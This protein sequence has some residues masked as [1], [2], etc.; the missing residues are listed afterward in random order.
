MIKVFICIATYCEI[1]LALDI[2]L[3]D[4]I[5]EMWHYLICLVLR[6]YEWRSCVVECGESGM[7]RVWFLDGCWFYSGRYL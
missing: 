3:R 7:V 4:V 2:Q 5:V 6:I 1:S